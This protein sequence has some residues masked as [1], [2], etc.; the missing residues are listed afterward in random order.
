MKTKNPSYK[1]LVQKF[2]LCGPTCLQMVLLRRGF[3]VD[4]EELA[5]MM[6]TKILFE[7]KDIY[8][9]P[10]EAV[11][12]S[13]PGRGSDDLS[14]QAEEVRE[15]LEGYGL[16]SLLHY[17]KSKDEIEELLHEAFDNDHDII[18]NIKLSAFFPHRKTGHYLIIHGFNH[19][20]GRV[21]LLDPDFQ[22]KK[23]WMC[24]LEDL[25]KAM[26]DEWDGKRR[27]IVLVKHVN[28]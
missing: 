7:K 20:E 17:P 8:L 25:E 23:E 13:H 3:W 19:N 28:E 9:Q 2:D 15:F 12:E 27:G 16:Q 26:S 11:D 24:S 21:I 10:F 5:H 22:N 18:V 1:H 4:Q 14:F 6:K